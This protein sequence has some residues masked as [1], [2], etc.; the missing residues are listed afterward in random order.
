MSDVIPKMKLQCPDQNP[1][2]SPTIT[3]DAAYRGRRSPAQGIVGVTGNTSTFL[4]FAQNI[5][6]C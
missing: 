4:I 6:V 2:H 5:C 3:P 1:S